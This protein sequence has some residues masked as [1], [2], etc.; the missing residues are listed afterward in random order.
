MNS[1]FEK[2]PGIGDKKLTKFISEWSLFVFNYRKNSYVTFEIQ[3]S[4]MNSIMLLNLQ[5]KGR[6]YLNIRTEI[7]FLNFC[8]RESSELAHQS[9]H[10]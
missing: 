6:D 10:C 8:A 1:D 3:M 5:L 2:P 4:V 9:I 7:L